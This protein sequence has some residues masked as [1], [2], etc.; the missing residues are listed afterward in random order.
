MSRPDSVI[1]VGL[2]GFGFVSKTFHVPLLQ[3]TDGYRI[4]AVSSS[5]PGE[6]RAMCGDAQVVSDAGDLAAHPDIDLVVIASPN[7]TH[8]PLAEAAMRAGWKA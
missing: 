1:R 8:A 5:K 2:V 4:T 7:K 3:A 6:V